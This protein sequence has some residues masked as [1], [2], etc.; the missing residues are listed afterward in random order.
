L[1]RN[2]PLNNEQKV[3]VVESIDLTRNVREVKLVFHTLAESFSFG[4]NSKVKK[5]VLSSTHKVITEGLASKTIGST[6]PSEKVILN[7]GT[8]NMANRFQKLAGIKPSKK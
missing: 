8:E 4:S 5:P 3:K 1:F 2:F 6:K 7:E